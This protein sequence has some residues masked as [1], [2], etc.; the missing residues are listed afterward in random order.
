[1][2]LNKFKKIIYHQYQNV[3]GNRITTRI[4]SSSSVRS[5]TGS[6]ISFSSTLST[7][8]T[9]FTAGLSYVN[10]KIKVN[11][12]ATSIGP[13]QAAGISVA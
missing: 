3:Y 6:F 1:M 10:W 4:G 11:R 5:R 13:G 8:F 9:S 12:L 7:F 2:Y